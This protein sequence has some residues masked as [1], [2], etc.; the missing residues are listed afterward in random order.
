[1]GED[2]IENDRRGIRSRKNRTQAGGVV[3]RRSDCEICETQIAAL[4]KQIAI[5][6]QAI[7]KVRR[8]TGTHLFSHESGSPSLP[9]WQI[10]LPEV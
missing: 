1:M 4:Q 2:K 3:R 7:L 5:T 9:P 6:R 8:Q 10:P